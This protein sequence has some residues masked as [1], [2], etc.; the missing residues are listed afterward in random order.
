MLL[1][2]SEAFTKTFGLGATFIG[3][4]IIVVVLV[5][6]IAVQIHGE[7]RQNK[8]YLASRSANGAG[9]AFPPGP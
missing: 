6:Y 9:D 4:N 3:I 1:A 7:R 2:T 5:I 8:E